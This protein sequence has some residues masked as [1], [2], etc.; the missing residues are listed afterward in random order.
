MA[1][2]SVTPPPPPVHSNKPIEAVDLHTWAIEELAKPEIPWFLD[3]IVMPKGLTLIA[4]KQKLGKSF[5]SMCMAIAM[6]T[7]EPIGLLKPVGRTKS[8]Y[9]DMEGSAQFTARRIQTL[10]KGLG[11]PFTQEAL[12]FAHIARQRDFQLLSSGNAAALVDIVQAQGIQ[13]VFLDT[14]ARSFQGDENSKQEIQVYL[15]TLSEIRNNT[16][17]AVVLVHHMNKDSY[18]NK[19]PVM[20]DPDAGMRGSTAIGGAYDVAV[21]IASGYIEGEYTTFAMSK[22]KYT[23]PWWAPFQVGG[24]QDPV[25]EEYTKSWVEFGKKD[26]EFAEYS[27]LKPDKQ[28]GGGGGKNTLGG[29][30]F[31]GDK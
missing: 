31:G 23:A 18:N 8:L 30:G 22:G 10:C 17:I 4:G 21:S 24:E 15:D 25:T 28:F 12:Q 6:S 14:I 9:F 26:R 29:K 5:L 20:M 7:G 27:S 11:I 2:R 19:S 13:V 16:G 3:K 1:L